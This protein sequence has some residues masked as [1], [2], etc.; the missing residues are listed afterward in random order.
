MRILHTSDWHLGISLHNVTLIEEQKFFIDG[1]ISVIQDQNIDVVIIAGDI[2]DHSVS[3][4]EA[5]RVY[6]RAMT[7]ICN[8]L[9]VP[10][11]I[12]AGNHDGAARLASCNELLKK[13][14]LHIAGK[15]DGDMLPVVIGDVAFHI[16]P[17]FSIDEVRYLFPG[18]E[19]KSYEVAMQTIVKSLFDRRIPGMQ[20]VLIG[21][22]FVSGAELSESDRSAALGGANI[23]S[24]DVF[25]GFDYVALGHLHRAQNVSP[26]VRY[27]GSPLKYSFSE[28]NNKKS[29]TMIDTSDMSISEMVIEPL[30]DL[31]LIRGEFL[32]VMDGA[33]NGKGTDDY[34][35]IE[36]TDSYA[37]L[38]KIDLFRNYYPNL[39]CLSGK[40]FEAENQTVTL[41][42]DEIS[43]LS[44]EDILLKFYSEIIG[45]EP[46]EELLAWFNSAVA[47][48]SEG[49]DIQ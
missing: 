17:F 49:D 44:T 29:V 39:L 45:E 34:I 20:N 33:E 15:I 48:T 12:C 23:V 14:G 21:H 28:S 18:T 47:A 3:S 4:A 43:T 26:T 6:N 8:D 5:I 42:V 30:H 2:F 36:L 35:K 46:D 32:E 24:K 13:S 41:T 7:A 38:E 22:C 16:L 27:S 1:L 25:D 11:L 37:G 10:V 9:N 31:R 19:I 40:S